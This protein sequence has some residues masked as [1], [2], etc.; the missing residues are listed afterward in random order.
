M[1]SR[2]TRLAAENRRL[3]KAR[4]EL[5][6]QLA[7]RTA[8][9]TRANAALRESERN[10]VDF[11][12]Q[13]P[14]GL[15]WVRADGRIQRINRAQ[16]ESLERTAENC[17]GRHV[18]ECLA[19]PE[20]AGDI[21]GRL[22]RKETLSNYR[23]RFRRQNGSS[24][25]VLIDANGLWRGGTLLSSRWF[26]RDIT[27]R[28]ALERELLA[29]AEREQ[30]RLG[31]DLHD[32]VCQQLSGIEF[33]SQTLA[34]QLAAGAA[35]GPVLSPSKGAARAREIARM[36][37][38]V[39]DHTRAL[40]QGLSP[41]GLEEAGLVV[42]LRDLVARTQ[43]IFHVKCR[44]RCSNPV[45]IE[46]GA[47]AIH[48]YR[49]AQEAISNALKHGRARRIS[50]ALTTRLPDL[51]LA[52]RDNGV[53]VPVPLRKGKGMGLRV[54]QHRSALIGGSLTVRRETRG[55]TSVICTV[56]GGLQRPSADGRSPLRQAQG[57]PRQPR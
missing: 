33:L 32:D 38:Q 29:I 28:V 25:H 42:A 19:D 2:L 45:L 36:L 39:M 23:A 57:R 5:E 16:L 44:F 8:E 11:F 53:G 30:K 1:K 9:V 12:Q 43:H 4:R 7:D 3:R 52:V 6:A 13:S 14:L 40:A 56:K 47:A 27:A 24:L 22:A 49:I 21:L 48:L 26:V 51:I 34:S 55:G 31:Q 20:V 46:D 54:M 41:V 37:R 18:S 15:L 17:L 10:L 50:I 35:P